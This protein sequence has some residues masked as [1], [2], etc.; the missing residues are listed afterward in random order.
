M[1]ISAI[2]PSYN[3]LE[4]LKRAINSVLNQDCAVDE[5][6]V[7]DDGSTDNTATYIQQNLPQIKL[8]QQTNQGV[9]AA[10][11]AG[12][13]RASC[14][15][16]ALLDSDD[17]WHYNKISTIKEHHV[18]QPNIELI[19]SDEIWIRNHVR[20]NAMNKHQKTGG[21]VFLRCLPLC[22]ISPSAVVLKRSLIESV[23]YFDESLPACED[24]DLWLKICCHH[25]VHYI[26]LPLITKY[27][28]HED[29]LS[30]QHWGM[31]RFRIRALSR[32]I[33]RDQLSDTYRLAANEMLQKKLK[34]L[35]K[36]AK[37]HNN[38][39]VLDEFSVMISPL[40]DQVPNNQRAKTT[41]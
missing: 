8:I 36:G 4:S 20:V 10:R 23:G 39:S 19:H 24:Y 35:L 15:W 21:H 40:I 34:V 30:T 14:D 27:G 1:R 7:V 41:C 17:S 29:Q 11:N 18:K 22:V 5:L 25:S 37:K 6:I 12:I 33:Q 16:I 2:I 38:Q 28:G 3:R 26:D 13:K 32:L 9:S 31:D